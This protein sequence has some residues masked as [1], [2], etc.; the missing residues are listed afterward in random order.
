MIL[1]K[2]IPLSKH[3]TNTDLRSPCVLRG[4]YEPNQEGNDFNCPS[5]SLGGGLSSI[6]V[7]HVK[8]CGRYRVYTQRI[9]VSSDVAV[10]PRLKLSVN[11]SSSIYNIGIMC[12]DCDIYNI[13]LNL[14]T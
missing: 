8:Q 3:G 5:H 4:N 14:N 1:Y 12:I 13:S 9:R 2:V 7:P 10:H 6:F 11:L